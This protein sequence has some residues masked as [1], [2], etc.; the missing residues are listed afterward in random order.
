MPT[1]A[2]STRGAR[3]LDIAWTI[4]TI[5]RRLPLTA[6][7]LDDSHLVNCFAA[8]QTQQHT[9][10]NAPGSSGGGDR[11]DAANK[12]RD[13][14]IRHTHWIALL[15]EVTNAAVIAVEPLLTRLN[16]LEDAVMECAARRERPLMQP[17][18]SHAPVGVAF[19]VVANFGVTFAGSN[20]ASSNG[21]NVDLRAKQC[22]ELS[23]VARTLEIYGGVKCL[24]W[25][26]LEPSAASGKGEGAKDKE[27]LMRQLEAMR[28]SLGTNPSS[29]PALLLMD[30]HRKRFYRVRQQSASFASPSSSPVPGGSSPSPAPAAVPAGIFSAQAIMHF[31][32]EFM[33]G[34]L[35]ELLPPVK[36]SKIIGGGVSAAKYA[37]IP[38]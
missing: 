9:S 3:A 38:M 10:T 19:L 32:E 37:L 35:N 4:D 25:D 21:A 31:S 23:K 12:D 28:L 15:S 13:R 30:L 2:T 22:I 34:S 11:K 36:G 7:N 33:R 29:Y 1:Q 20:G 14:A 26:V 27:I 6:V 5:Q 18:M 17:Y 8:A 16:D 24:A